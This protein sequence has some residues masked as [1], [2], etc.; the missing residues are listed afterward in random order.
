MRLGTQ[1]FPGRHTS[2]FP[3]RALRR[4][5]A[6]LA[7]L[8][9]LLLLWQ[10]VT[11]LQLYPAF[12]IPPPA[13]VFEKLVEVWADG[14]LLLHTWVTLQAVLAGLAAGL[15]VGVT[16]GY[17]IARSPLL[18]DSL[19]PLLVGLQSTPIVAWAPLLVIWF[20]SG[21]TSKAI[22]SALIVFFPT[23]VNTVVGLRNVPAS[24]LDLLRVQRATRR[25]TL[26]VLEIPAALPVLF[27]GLKVSATLAVIGAVVGEFVSADAGLGF[28][29]TLARSR[30]DTPLVLVAVFAL[31]VMA[32]LLY[33]AVALLERHLLAWQ[34]PGRPTWNVS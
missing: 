30:Y 21:L 13:A 18:E 19:A 20:G 27:A 16:L 2:P 7:M 26:L 11:A 23:L 3:A 25:Q 14:S 10:L 1:G 28:L 9:A 8:F 31:A 24:L 4:R 32:R 17:L 22:T 34:R 29:I 15:L 6:P 5:L 12:I 33:G